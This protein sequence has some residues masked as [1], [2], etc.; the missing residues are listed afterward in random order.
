[1]GFEAGSSLFPSGL[2]EVLDESE[3]R[4]ESGGSWGS[5]AGNSKEVF[6][7]REDGN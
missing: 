6:S 1:M 3:W 4:E 5:G 2:L 7:E